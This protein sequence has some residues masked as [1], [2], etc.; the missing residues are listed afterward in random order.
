MSAPTW[1]ASSTSSGVQSKPMSMPC[2]SWEGEP[3]IKPLLC[4][5]SDGAF[6]G[7]FPAFHEVVYLSEDFDIFRGIHSVS[8]RV[9]V[10]FEK[11]AEI[12]R[13]VPDQRH[14]LAEP[15]RHF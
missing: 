5:F 14:V 2:T 6:E 9:S 11:F 7:Q 12:I 1:M 10:R 13:P 3:I 8:L 4:H 15:I